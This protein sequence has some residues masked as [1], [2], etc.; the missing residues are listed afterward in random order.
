LLAAAVASDW[1]WRD[2]CVLVFL[3]STLISW[4]YEEVDSTRDDG[5][6][7]VSAGRK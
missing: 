1:F 3:F 6:E 7:N 5:L 2:Y 4:D